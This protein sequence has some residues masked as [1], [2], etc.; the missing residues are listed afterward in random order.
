MSKVQIRVKTL[1][2]EILTFH[3]VESYAS[4]NGFLEFVDAKTGRRKSFPIGSCEIEEAR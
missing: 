4:L 3:G 2:G 1:D